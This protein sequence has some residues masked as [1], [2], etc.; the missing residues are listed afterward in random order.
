MKCVLLT[1]RHDG[2]HGSCISLIIRVRFLNRW[3]KMNM[4]ILEYLCVQ[5]KLRRSYHGTVEGHSTSIE[6]AHATPILLNHATCRVH[7]E[8]KQK[9][10]KSLL[11]CSRFHNLTC[12]AASAITRQFRILAIHVIATSFNFFRRV[13]WNA[14]VTFLQSLNALVDVCVENSHNM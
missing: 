13:A 2:M 14:L 11:H 6:S 10:G 3:C 7:R 4:S 5:S 12:V 8:E 9:R 1:C